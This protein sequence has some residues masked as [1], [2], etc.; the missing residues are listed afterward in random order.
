[1]EVIGQVEVWYPTGEDDQYE[2]SYTLVKL[3]N[4]SDIFQARSTSQL[5][6]LDE[7]ESS[8]IPRRKPLPSVPARALSR[9]WEKL[10]LDSLVLGPNCGDHELV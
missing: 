8:L 7:T 1:M 2:W 10:V 6:E 5:M 3:E 9:F 4:N